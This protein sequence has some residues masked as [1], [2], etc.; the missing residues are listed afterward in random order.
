MRRFILLVT[1]LLTLGGLAGPSSAAESDGS[2]VVIVD[3]SGSMARADA[4]GTVLM[5]GARTALRDLLAKVPANSNIGLRLYGHTYA[6]ANKAE[7][8]RDTELVVP[9]GPASRTA[10]DIQSAMDDAKPTGWT[11][12]GGSLQAAADDFPPEGQ[13][14]IILISD[15][16]DTCGNPEPCTAAEAL[17]KQGIAVKVDTI[18]LFLQDNRAAKQQLECVAKATG[19]TFYEVDEAGRLGEQLGAVG[20]RAIEQ[21]QAEGTDIDGGPSA[22]RATPIKAGTDYTDDIGQGEARW[23]SV[24]VPAGATP[25]VEVTEDGTVE[26]GCCMFVKLYD[27]QGKQVGFENS[28]NRTG[29]AKTYRIDA[30]DPSAGGGAYDIE[31]QVQKSAAM[32]GTLPFQLQV[33]LPEGSDAGESPGPTDSH[34][35]TAAASDAE[36]EGGNGLAWAI[37][38]VLGLAVLGLGAGLVA[39]LRRQ[40]SAG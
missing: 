6:G 24:D 12:I 14:S 7:G 20:G 8:C 11:P 25:T 17:A 40:R 37:A 10:S 18:G 16:E 26:Y 3:I 33:T 28:Y 22:T 38:G 36:D 32:T 21:F 2:I 39:M 1:A 5:Q 35:D 4:A 29:T 9:I 31:V 23:F 30:D 27:P 34:T 15:G 13:R 19:G